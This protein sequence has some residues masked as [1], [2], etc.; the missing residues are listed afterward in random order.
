MDKAKCL[1]SVYRI[2]LMKKFPEKCEEMEKLIFRKRNISRKNI[3][4]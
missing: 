3:K 1:V 4:G 2:F